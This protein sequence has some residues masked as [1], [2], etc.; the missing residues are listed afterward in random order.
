MLSDD[1]RFT[2]FQVQNESPYKNLYKFSNGGYILE[3]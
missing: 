3:S 1:L 2:I